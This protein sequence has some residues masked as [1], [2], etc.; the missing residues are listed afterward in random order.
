MATFGKLCMRVTLLMTLLGAMS[1]EVEAVPTTTDTGPTTRCEEL[2]STDF[3]GI[4]DAPTQIVNAKLV[5]ASAG[6]QPYCKVQGYVWPQVGFELWLPVLN[7][8]GKLFEVGC[9]GSCGS[10]FWAI[11]CPLQRGYACIASD[12]GHTG[13]SQDLSWSYNN[14]QAQI[15]YDIRGTHVT[16]LAGK[17]ITARYYSKASDKAYFMGCSTG[18]RQALAEAQRF[19]WDFDGI[20]GLDGSP[21]FTAINMEYLWGERALRG[22]GGRS[23]LSHKDLQLVHN[24]ALARCDMDDGVKDGIISDP[25]HCNFDPSELVCKAGRKAECL[26]EAQVEA[27]KKVYAGPVTSKGEKKNYLR[28]SAPGSELGWV[29]YQGL[30]YVQSGNGLGGLEE[31]SL[32]VFRYMAFTPAPGS[33]WKL[34]D[35]D[36]DR[37]YKRLGVLAALVDV[38]N[39]DLRAFKDAGGKL[40]YAYGMNDQNSDPAAMMDYYDNAE[41]VMGGRARTQEFFRLFMVPGMDHCTGGDGAFAIDYLTY[42][43]NWVER[44]EPPD[45]VIGAHVDN[46]YLQEHSVFE[47]KQSGE[48]MGALMLMS[49]FPLDSTIPVTFTRP[50]YPYPTRAKYSGSG[51]PNDAASFGP[52][53]P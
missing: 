30:E 32:E 53:E 48:W 22:E 10:V 25:Y 50:I 40:I 14:L 44:G 49:K 38:T 5:E 6:Q 45:K 13:K 24:E 26:T 52:V 8:N 35:F 18:G 51:D 7:W 46:R 28:G 17:A 12:M 41:K 39:P 27:V 15:D 37:D 23:L 4:Q 19:P 1:R 34:T 3:S 20:I 36:F 2:T 21:S 9:G 47:G 33:R 16:A 43:E 42:L 11:L 31:W 29:D